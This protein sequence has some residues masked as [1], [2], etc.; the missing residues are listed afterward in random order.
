MRERWSNCERDIGRYEQPALNLER[1]HHLRCGAAAEHR[2]VDRLVARTSSPSV[3]FAEGNLPDQSE[4][5]H[6]P[7]PEELGLLVSFD[8]FLTN[9]LAGEL[10]KPN[11]PFVDR[12]AIRVEVLLGELPGA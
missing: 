2:Q 3:R 6:C 4:S 10:V 1:D 8:G 5:L 7:C 11:P 9:F 12:L